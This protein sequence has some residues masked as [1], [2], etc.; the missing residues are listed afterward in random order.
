MPGLRLLLAAP[1]LALVACASAPPVQVSA[2]TWSQV[3]QAIATASREAEDQARRL[4]AA[5][6]EGCEKWANMGVNRGRLALYHITQAPPPELPASLIQAVAALSDFIEEYPVQPDI[7]N[8]YN[9]MMRPDGTLV[10]SDPVF[11][12]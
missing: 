1:L 10:L 6:W 3:D 11:L 2:H 4:S 7:L 9:L 8:P 12:P 5:Y